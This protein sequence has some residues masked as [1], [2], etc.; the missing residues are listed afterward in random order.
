M[1]SKIAVILAGTMLAITGATLPASAIVSSTV[2]QEAINGQPETL[3]LAAG[4]THT[5]NARPSTSEKHQNGQAK[6]KQS[7]N[8]SAR[9][10]QGKN[11]QQAEQA[12]KKTKDKQKQKQ[13]QEQQ[14]IN[15][16]R[17]NQGIKK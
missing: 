4:G 9:Y 12:N 14:R 13:K 10:Q 11:K 17:K 5:N 6:K 2:S 7:Q 15:Q 1:K 3:L 16:E 8:N